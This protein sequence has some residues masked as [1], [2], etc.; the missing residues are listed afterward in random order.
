MSILSSGNE[1]LGLLLEGWNA[2]GRAKRL[3][4]AVD[5]WWE[6]ARVLEMPANARAARGLVRAAGPADADVAVE[7]EWLGGP[8]AFVGARRTRGR[9][10]ETESFEDAVGR[11]AED[12]P[13]HPAPALE[14][15]AGGPPAELD[16]VELGAA[17]AWR[18]VGPMRLWTR[19]DEHAPRSVAAGLSRR[20]DLASC[21]V[22]VA[23]A[24]AY[25]GPRSCWFGVEVSEPSDGRHAVTAKAVDALLARLFAPREQA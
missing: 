16:H 4:L 18:S 21:T 7:V 17:N 6:D 19:G 15:V 11:I 1:A 12:D 10:S 13:V 14:L 20:P 5:G 3:Q 24:L 8:L 9:D 22:P 25:A 2:T 23:I